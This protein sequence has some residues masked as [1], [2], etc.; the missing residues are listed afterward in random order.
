MHIWTILNLNYIKLELIK[1][2]NRFLF[3]SNKKPEDLED[4]AIFDNKSLLVIINL[5]SFFNSRY[6]IK[7]TE[8][9]DN[10]TCIILFLLFHECLGHQK[11]NINNEKVI[12]PRRHYDSNFKDIIEDKVDTGIALE[13]ILFGEIVDLESLMESGNLDKLLEPN[14]YIGKDFN[15]LRNI[16][17]MIK[18]KNNYE[19]EKEESKSVKENNKKKEKIHH[20]KEDKKNSN[21]LLHDLFKIYSNVSDKEKESLKDNED[22]K[23]FLMLYEKKKKPSSYILPRFMENFNIKI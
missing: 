14:L 17:Y 6:D 3:L 16:Y 22:Y 12:T 13:K 5:Y 21:K 18:K 10:A 9:Y 23:R 11:K 1:N 19:D 2:I 4:F 7:K 15:N 8:E 20:D